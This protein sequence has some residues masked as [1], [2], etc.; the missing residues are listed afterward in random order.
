[1]PLKSFKPEQYQ[2]LLNEKSL[3]IDDLFTELGFKPSPDVFPSPKQAFRC[4]AEFRFWHENNDSFYA[5]FEQGKKDVPVRIDTFPIAHQHIQTLMPLC[6]DIVVRNELLRQRL[7]QVEFLSTLNNQNLITLIY[8]KRLDEEWLGAAEAMQ[9][10]LNETLASSGAVIKLI[11]RSKKQKITL[12]DDFVDEQLSVDGKTLCYRQIEGSFTQ[13]NAYV[14]QHM[15]SW[16]RAQCANLSLKPT[17]DLLELYCGNGNFTAALAPYFNQVLATEISKSSV[18]A[19]QHNF[20]E[21]KIKNVS[22]CRLSSEEITQ[23]LNKVREFRRLKQQSIELDSYN[24]STVF[25]DP[26]RA[27]LDEETLQLVS[28]FEYILY[29]SCNPET[30]AANLT[31]L[32]GTHTIIN[33]AIFDQFPY[34]HHIES[35][36]ILKKI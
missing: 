16:A 10:E 13:P 1:M 2:T 6:K 31:V 21:N 8:H 26:P 34:T 27:G 5:M 32:L 25:V 9:T 11:G 28:Q 22:V 33:T 23:A 15:L 20:I 36:V 12:V 35:G 14:N 18:R 29:I 4:R 3:R 17:D 24:F 7:F 30:L 19:A